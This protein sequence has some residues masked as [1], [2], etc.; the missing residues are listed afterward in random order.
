MA[1]SKSS[2]YQFRFIG[3]PAGEAPPTIAVLAL[4]AAGKVLQRSEVGEDGRFEFPADV[5][6]K[7]ARVLVG[8]ADADPAEVAAFS[9]FRP[10]AFEDMLGAEINIAPGLWERWRF[11]TRCA[12]GTVWRCRRSP[13]WFEDLVTLARPLPARDLVLRAGG[14]ATRIPA[15]RSVDE[16]IALPVRCRP[17]C[18]GV[19]EVW[20]RT[21]CCRP[22]VIFDPRLEDLLEELEHLVRWPKI[23]DFPPPP[24]PP[25]PEPGPGPDPVPFAADV[26]LPFMTDGSLD[27][28]AVNA[29]RDL[30][31]IRRL[32]AAEVAGYI[33][34]RPWLRCRSYSCSAPVKVGEGEINPDG[35]FNVCW[36]GLPPLLQVG[37]HEEYAYRVRQR[38]GPFWVTVYNGV[39]TNAWFAPGADA[40]L[41]SYHPLAFA[42]RPPGDP[43]TGA[44]VYLDLIGDTSSHELE[45]PAAQGWDRVFTPG[46]TGGTLFNAPSPHGHKRNLGGTLK[47]SY[48][49]SE[50]LKL[51][52]ARYYRISVVEADAFGDPV[53]PRTYYSEG[54]SWTKAVPSGTGIDVVPVSLGPNPA[55][56]GGQNHL[57]EIPFDLTGGQEWEDGQYHAHINTDA[58]AWSNP[59]ARHLITLE[60]FDSTGR[61]LRPNGAPATGQPG[62]ETTAA[63]TYRRKTAA[64]GPTQNVPFGALSHLFWWDNRPL[65]AS[66][67]Q[68]RLDGLASNAE[69][70]FLTGVPGSQ[71]SIEYRAYHPEPLFQR[72]HGITWKRGLN[73]PPSGVGTLLAASPSNVGQPPA[74]PGISPSASFGT[75]L[76]L[77]G[78]PTRT[79]CAFTVFLR[80]NGK[81][82][83]GDDY[84][85]PVRVESAAFALGVG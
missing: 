30:A 44:F 12:T 25:F 71:F 54:L 52:D 5:L 7:S 41:N 37:C 79:R 26:T 75:M 43:G 67:E 23:P 34:A 58:A 42:C 13:W 28:M 9:R 78:D 70:Q 2:R 4:D 48:L 80:I 72:D 27:L 35:R 31:A 18:N 45:T 20:R 19:V 6:K 61:R 64:L 46:P 40:R 50:D 53:G 63:F 8:P 24:P 81:R 77:A 59:L 62:A 14:A 22:W 15:A 10:R 38:F 85:Y 60:I 83:D 1:G 65:E 74:G 49:F 56:I 17:I 66:I 39:D 82:T 51:L 47:L 73:P 36:R 69:C 33:G 76:D 68:L 57:Y 11:F 21:C 3:L 55:P 84:G 29:A 32:P 16:L